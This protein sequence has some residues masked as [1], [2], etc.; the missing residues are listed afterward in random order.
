MEYFFS[1]LAV[2]LIAIIT[3][4]LTRAFATPIIVQHVTQIKEIHISPK[5]SETYKEE[6]I[7]TERHIQQEPRA[8]ERSQHEMRHRMIDKLWEEGWLQY[9]EYEQRGRNYQP[10]I[11]GRM[12]L[13]V[14]PPDQPGITVRQY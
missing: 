10:E 13:N 1:C 11:L 6:V 3:H 2:Y 4:A 5:G 12:T 14:M 9:A 7:L 8:R